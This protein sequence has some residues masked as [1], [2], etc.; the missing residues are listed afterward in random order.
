[1]PQFNTG[2]QTIKRSPFGWLGY[3]G[4][5]KQNEAY[6]L[7]AQWGPVTQNSLNQ[8][9]QILARRQQLQASGAPQQ[10]IDAGVFDQMNSQESAIAGLEFSQRNEAQSRVEANR[11]EALR[12]AK[13]RLTGADPELL[14]MAEA[15]VRELNIH[16][17]A[18][19]DALKT[20]MYDAE[21]QRQRTKQDEEL[22]RAESDAARKGEG[23]SGKTLAAIRERQA[24]ER[25]RGL[26][27]ID[28]STGE[29]ALGN[30]ERILGQTIALGQ[31]QQRRGD[32]LSENIG[33]RLENRTYDV[34]QY[35]YP[36]RAP[37]TTLGS[38]KYGTQMGN[39]SSG[40]DSESRQA[41]ATTYGGNDA[42]TVPGYDPNSRYT[43]VG[44]L[45]GNLTPEEQAQMLK[46]LRP[47]TRL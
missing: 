11:D 23:A 4:A 19:I 20:G 5:Q 3:E 17:D 32:I 34:P 14:Q 22:R 9:T 13:E 31:S 21:I 30:R 33:N 25:A 7:A 39:W 28:L 42:I 27:D 43:S 2:P 44:R 24:M 46:N 29:M 35:Q 15:Q 37:I 16:P 45:R 38:V 18:M 12:M 26:R 40:T 1:M 47:G 10:L 8:A 6:D 36:T 41:P